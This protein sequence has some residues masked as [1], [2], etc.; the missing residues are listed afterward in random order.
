[1][2]VISDFDYTL[3]RFEDN[4]GGRC[5]TTHGVF[6]NCSKQ[7]DPE[8]ALKLQ[9]LKERYFPVEFDPKM[10]QEQKVP[11]MEQ[12]QVEQFSQSHCFC[13]IPSEHCRE[14]CAEFKNNI[15]DDA[16]IEI[17]WIFVIFLANDAGMEEKW[18]FELALLRSQGIKRDQAEQMIIRLNQ[19]GVPLVVFSAGIGNIIEMYLEQRLGQIPTNIRIISNMMNFDENVCS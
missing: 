8:L 15:E 5:W 19:L 7:V 13:Q 6:D 12:W 4:L 11:Y 16:E 10:T 3:S 1:M 17:E 18:S 2:Q 9:R 14:F